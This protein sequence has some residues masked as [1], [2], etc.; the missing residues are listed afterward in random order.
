MTSIINYFTSL[1]TTQE[2]L[3]NRSNKYAT[4]NIKTV[5]T[6]LDNNI[7]LPNKIKKHITIKELIDL[8]NNNSV[9]VEDI[10]NKHC[11]KDEIINATNTINNTNNNML[12]LQHNDMFDGKSLTVVNI[13]G[14]YWFKGKDIA[15][16]LEYKDT[17]NAVDINVDNDDKKKY[18]EF[19]KGDL[20]SPLKFKGVFN[21]P[22]KRNEKNTIY[23]N[24]SGLYSLILSSKK[25]I[26]KQFKH[27][28][29]SDVLPQLRKTGN[30]ISNTETINETINSKSKQKQLTKPLTANKNKNNYNILKTIQT[31]LWVR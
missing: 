5:L 15:L 28:I 4:D 24:E 2:V 21:T 22:L 6:Q 30:Y 12:N 29:T 16:M 8:L 20:K 10:V 13:N 1:F 9:D 31:M 19:F 14:D 27:W 26:A 23:V 7:Q 25:P 11:K 18:S 17:K 3:T